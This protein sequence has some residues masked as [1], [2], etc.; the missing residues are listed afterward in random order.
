MA[1]SEH[2]VHRDA[3][4]RG[5]ATNL[6][7]DDLVAAVARLMK[8][9]RKKASTAVDV[10]LKTIRSSLK[11]G[12]VVRVGGMGLTMLQ[13][14]SGRKVINLAAEPNIDR[15][16]KRVAR[17]T[18]LEKSAF[19]LDA[20]ARA[21]LR[22][23]KMREHDLRAAGGAFDFAELKKLLGISRQAV[24]KR[25]RS[26]SLLAVPGPGNRP[27][28]PAVQFDPNG[29]VVDGL[30]DVSAALPNRNPW[31]FLNFLVNPDPRLQKRRPIDLLKEGNVKTVVDSARRINEQ[32]G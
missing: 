6:R 8:V 27:R 19:E 22:G 17:Q 28:Y 5:T 25:V 24:D 30:R 21:I 10:T 32:G 29:S 11:E 13:L 9:P 16:A 20:R 7:K 4:R 23:V 14:K 31:L 1:Q 18:A 15:V 3:S 26:G 12:N 2:K